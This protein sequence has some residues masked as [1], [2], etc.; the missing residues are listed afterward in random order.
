M[1]PLTVSL[2]DKGGKPDKKPYPI[3]NQ[4]KPQ[5]WE[6]SRLGPETLNEIVR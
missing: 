2:K 3:R 5:V 1:Q 4:Q 6:L